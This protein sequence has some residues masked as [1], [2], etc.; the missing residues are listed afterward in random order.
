MAYASQL[1]QVPGIHSIH[2]TVTGGDA[3]LSIISAATTDIG[4]LQSNRCIIT[5]FATITSFGTVPDVI[6]FI[7]FGGPLILTYNSTSLV[8]PTIANIVT[9][10]DDAC[11]AMSDSSGNWRVLSY[12][13]ANGQALSSSGGGSGG[14]LTRQT[15]TA[16]AG[17]TVFA[18]SGGYSAG[19]VDVYRNGVKLQPVVEVDITSGS[20]VTLPIASSLDDII[21]VVGLAATSSSNLADGNKG[22]VTVSGGAST[23]AVN[24]NVI[25]NAKLAQV[26]TGVIK[27][28]VTAGTGSV[29]D[30][31]STQVTTLLG[32]GTYT[33]VQGSPASTWTIDH[34]LGRYP[35]ISV[36]DSGGSLVFGEVKYNTSNQAQ[37]SFSAAFSGQAYLN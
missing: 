19:N 23:I 30:L 29:E 31:T 16:T 28:R 24:S 36:V 1:E 32:L 4:S 27:G 25:T 20:I 6:R 12:T 9:A 26:A 7:R 15:F 10:T 37:V 14:S 22:D 11:I 17:Q 18:V 34:N 5:G 33:H 8:L 2:R 35:S 3:E 21:Q 13:K